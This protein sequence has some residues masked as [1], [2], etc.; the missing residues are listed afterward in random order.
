MA[1]AL[2][3]DRRNVP[4][5]A[6]VIDIQQSYEANTIV[7]LHWRNRLRGG[8]YFLRPHIKPNGEN[9]G[10]NI[11]SMAPEPMI[12]GIMCSFSLTL[13]S[14]EKEVCAEFISVKSFML[15]KRSHGT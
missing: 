6:L 1:Q 9:Q 5:N 11:V 2:T 7:I 12:L 13:T 15:L 8:H 14:D 4:P 10:S 3:K